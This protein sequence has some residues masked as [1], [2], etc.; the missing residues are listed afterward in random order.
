[1]G[2]AEFSSRS[3]RRS[4]GANQIRNMRPRNPRPPETKMHGIQNVRPNLESIPPK[5]LNP[6]LDPRKLAPHRKLAPKLAPQCHGTSHR[7]FT[8]N[9]CNRSS[10]HKTSYEPRLPYDDEIH[11]VQTKFKNRLRSPESH[12]PVFVNLL[13]S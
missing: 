7:V 1:M 2:I 6:K 5:C 10:L 3:R 13:G 8:P 9:L 11:L 4:L 12:T